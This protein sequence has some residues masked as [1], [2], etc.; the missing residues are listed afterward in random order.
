MT[1]FVTTGYLLFMKLTLQILP[2]LKLPCLV[3]RLASLQL[4]QFIW[5]LC[6]FIQWQMV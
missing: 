4:L 2:Y 3:D 1:Y 6:L 5:I